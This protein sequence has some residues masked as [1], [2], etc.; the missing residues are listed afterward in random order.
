MAPETLAK[1]YYSNKTDVWAFG[2]LLYEIFHGDSP[3]AK[4]TDLNDLLKSVHTPITRATLRADLSAELK[5]LILCCLE[6]SV[7]KRPRFAEIE[8][9]AYFKK[10]YG[11][12]RPA[13]ANPNRRLRC[14]SELSLCT[15]KPTI[16]VPPPRR[17]VSRYL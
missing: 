10:L 17:Q 12:I 9:S 3:F 7:E 16:T 2:V 11:A 14:A 8:Q 5:Q 15:P 4:C 13:T 6:I 1:T